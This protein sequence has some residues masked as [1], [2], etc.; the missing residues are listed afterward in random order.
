[1]GSRYRSLHCVAGRGD[2][3]DAELAFRPDMPTSTSGSIGNP[4][5][6]SMRLRY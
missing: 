4:L 3:A 1:M 2:G 5:R 6:I